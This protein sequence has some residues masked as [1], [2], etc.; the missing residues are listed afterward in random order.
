MNIVSEML[1]FDFM[2]N[3]FVAGVALAICAALLGV[4]L[5][6]RRNSMIGDGLS[7]AAFAAFA[8][9][10]VFGWMPLP[11]ALVVV[12]L[13]SFAVLRLGRRH[14]GDAAIAI[15]SAGSLA[16]GTFAIS[17]TRGVNVDINSYL[18][19]S[20]LAVSGGEKWLALGLAFVMVGLFAMAFHR[21][22]ALTFD[23]PFARTVGVRTKFYDG[24]FAA[25]CS[26]VIVVGMRLLGSLLISA[27]IIFPALTA[28]RL[29]RN[30]KETTILAV[31]ISVFTFVLGLSLSYLLS[32]PAGSTIVLIDL[33]VFALACAVRKIC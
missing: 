2:Q 13:L 27:L 28:M 11:F 19:G 12:T 10:I 15:L 30:F 6:L 20:I 5:V 22:F 8:I 3:A 21:I 7:H 32:A 14:N 29:A 17:I 1:S 18:F 16:V 25:I 4:C 31:I 23:E 24:L 33:A 9:A 26:V